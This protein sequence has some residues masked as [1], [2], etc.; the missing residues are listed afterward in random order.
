MKNLLTIAAM[1]AAGAALAATDVDS[2]NMFGFVPV[3]GATGLKA[4]AVPVAGYGASAD[5]KIAEIL[6]T[7]GLAGK[8]A[9]Y[10]GDKLYT[11]AAGGK[12]NEYVLQEDKTWKASRV[13]TVGASGITADSGKPA[14]EATLERGQAFWL[15][16]TATTVYLMG[17]A[18]TEAVEIEPTTGWQMIG[19]PSMTA[20]LK[21]S[22]VPGVAGAYLAVGA[23]KYQHLG[24]GDGWYNA[25]TR[26]AVTDSDVIAVGQG[27]M[28]RKPQA[29]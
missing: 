20:A 3:T 18:A 1:M 21:V 13:V 11:M 4:I 5:V 2:G 29:N 22:D 17:Q 6:Q 24:E 9:T 14:D 28:Y 19:N 25:K 8:S 26:K 23:N 27:A 12:Y 7:T 15:D 10:D 16:T